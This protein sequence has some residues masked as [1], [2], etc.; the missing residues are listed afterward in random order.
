MNTILNKGVL[1]FLA[2]LAA[3]VAVAYYAQ[4]YAA[5][6]SDAV[7]IVITVMTVFAGF[8]VAIIA[9]LGDPALLPPGSW[10]RAENERDATLGAIISH[11]WLFRVYLL[12][13]ALLFAG[14]LVERA[15]NTKVPEHIKVWIE[16]AYLMV[17]SLS[18][19]LTLALPG[20]LTRFQQKRVDAEIERRR[21]EAGIKEG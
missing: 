9:V 8:L 11:A 21:R 1:F 12:A 5:H 14:V 19:F 13:I 7:L 15:P 18:F 17:G 6:N 4:P 20:A 2:C 10:R 3:S 16:R